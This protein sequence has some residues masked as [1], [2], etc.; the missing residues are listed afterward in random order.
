ML[1]HNSKY[2]HPLLEVSSNMTHLPKAIYGVLR[3][4]FYYN[5]RETKTNNTN[6]HHPACEQAKLTKK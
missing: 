5:V 1:Q 6:Y 4:I 3:Q 2:W